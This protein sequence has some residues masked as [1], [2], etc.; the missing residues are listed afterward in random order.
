MIFD[1]I[2][3]GSNENKFTMDQL[4]G[5][6][7]YPSIYPIH[8]REMKGKKMLM[9]DKKV[10]NLRSKDFFI[11]EKIDGTNIR[12]IIDKKNNV[13]IGGRNDLLA[14]S[15][16]IL[17]QNKNNV[18]D[19]LNEYLTWSNIRELQE[20]SIFNK[21]DLLVLYGELFGE[22]IQKKGKFYGKKNFRLFAARSFNEEKVNTILRIKRKNWHF[23]R[24]QNSFNPFLNFASVNNIAIILE[25]DYVP[26]QDI[27][28]NINKL[29]TIDQVQRLLTQFKD[30]QLANTRVEG[31]VLHSKG[32]YKHVTEGMNF[33]SFKL[34]FSDYFSR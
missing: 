30:S 20:S 14:Y 17:V 27:T 4:N 24:R 28:I 12:I 21:I 34:K 15:K 5:M 2:V 16:D 11:T 32:D 8:L 9:I 29:Q 6:T 7:K 13:V 18:I 10:H 3:V 1:N 26:V 25:M 19:V 33:A 22:G 23:L 31:L